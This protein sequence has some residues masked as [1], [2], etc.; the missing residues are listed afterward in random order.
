MRRRKSSHTATPPDRD[1]ADWLRWNAVVPQ[2]LHSQFKMKYFLDARADDSRCILLPNVT[3]A[4]P[5]HGVG[6]DDQQPMCDQCND[7]ANPVRFT[8]RAFLALAA[9]AAGF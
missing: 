1:T 5:F 7:P 4:H 8:R 2:N 3:Q 6:K 9:G